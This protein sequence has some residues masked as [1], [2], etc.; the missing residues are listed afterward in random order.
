MQ[1]SKGRYKD[2]NMG[3]MPLQGSHDEA[4]EAAV[5]DPRSSERAIAIEL[6]YRR[7]ELEDREEGEI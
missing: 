2:E 5:Y 3:T 4:I 6:R 1:A 7:E